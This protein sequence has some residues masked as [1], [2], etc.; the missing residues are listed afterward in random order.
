LLGDLHAKLGR[1]DIF[2]P[3]TGGESLHEIS[4]DNGVRV[5]NFT[6]SNTYIYLYI[7]IYIHTHIFT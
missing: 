2:N 5:V 3:T 7:F 4:Y 1:E 6:T